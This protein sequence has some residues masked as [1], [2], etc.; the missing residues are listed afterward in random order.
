MVEVVGKGVGTGTN[1]CLQQQGLVLAGRYALAQ[2]IVVG[3]VLVNIAETGTKHI[4]EGIEPLHRLHNHQQQDVPRVVAEHVATLVEQYLVAVVVVVVL[5]DD[6]AAHPAIRRYVAGVAVDGDAVYRIMPQA[7]PA[8][9][10]VH[11]DEL[12]ETYADD[13][14]YTYYI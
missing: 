11:T 1:G 13:N 8:D 12:P 6:D 14:R 3:L 9:E 4:D 5:A 2:H 7:T 10:A